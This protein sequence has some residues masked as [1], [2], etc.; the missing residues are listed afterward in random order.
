MEFETIHE[1]YQHWFDTRARLA[2][3]HLKRE[4]RWI[5]V[6]WEAFEEK[7]THFALGL[8]ALGMEYRDPVTILALTREEWD[9]ADKATL[10]AGGVSVGCYHSNTP[11]QM[12]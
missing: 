12:E 5:P 8:M 6:T 9:I 7:M 3:Y 11:A 1:M 4:G 2:A 10:S